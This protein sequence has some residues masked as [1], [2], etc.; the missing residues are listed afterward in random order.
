MSGDSPAG[1]QPAPSYPGLAA[2]QAAAGAPLVVCDLELNGFADAVKVRI[3]EF[4]TVEVDAAGLPRCE[5]SLVQT[6]TPIN[7]FVRKKTGIRESTLNGYPTW[8]HFAGAFARHAKES[9]LVLFSSDGDVMSFMEEFARLGIPVPQFDRVLDVQPV[10]RDALGLPNM[11]SLDNACKA[12]DVAFQGDAHRALADTIATADL[13]EA[14]LR[15][16]APEQV[17]KA[18]GP[19][20]KSYSLPLPPAAREYLEARRH[21]EGFSPMDAAVALRAPLSRLKTWLD[22]LNGIFK[23][24]KRR[25]RR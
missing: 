13:L 24:P 18:I 2:L 9:V 10:A 14:I 16:V 3:I 7:W 11:P 12:L 23:E 5:H 1:P 8:D 22:E 21:E 17:A 6:H 25:P 19:R 20:G 15:K 4:A